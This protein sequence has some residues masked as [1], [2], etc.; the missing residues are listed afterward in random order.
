[1]PLLEQDFARRYRAAQEREH[2]P[3]DLVKST[4]SLVEQAEREHQHASA[5]DARY[6]RDRSDA[7]PSEPPT[8]RRDDSGGL[9]GG[10]GTV[11]P[12][13]SPRNDRTSHT[14]RHDAR[15]PHERSVTHRHPRWI[16][17]IAACLAAS[18][19][20]FGIGSAILD[21]SLPFIKD[22][23][24]TRA[25]ARTPNLLAADADGAIIPFALDDF[26]NFQNPLSFVEGFTG[27]M[28]T[29]EGDGI[30]RVQATIDRG[31][32]YSMTAET[33]TR[34]KAE[35]VEK[36]N[37]AL[38][39]SHKKRG[40]GT[41]LR[42]Y[43]LVTTIP[44]DDGFDYS[45]ANKSFE[46]RMAK[47]LGSTI[48]VAYE[49]GPLTLGLWFDDV[50]YIEEPGSNGLDWRPYLHG[51]DGR[52]LT[53][54]TVMLDGSCS[55]Q[56]IE[57]HDGWFSILPAGETDQGADWITAEGPFDA[58]PNGV[59][60]ARQT[61][62]GEVTS[63]TDQPHPFPLDGASE[64]AD[65]PAD[66]YP[67]EELIDKASN[68][69]V[70]GVPREDQIV[71][72]DSS[73]SP[74]GA[75]LMSEQRSNMRCLQWS[76]VSAYITDALPDD[77][78]IAQLLGSTNDHEYFNR[79]NMARYGWSIDEEG[80][81][82]GNGSFLVV[83]ATLTNASDSPITFDGFSPVGTPCIVDRESNTTV[84]P[85]SGSAF[86][87]SDDRGR[88]WEKNVPALEPRETVRLRIIYITDDEMQAAGELF[89]SPDDLYLDPSVGSQVSGRTFDFD[90]YLFIS[91]GKLE[92]R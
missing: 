57:L 9:A 38:N 76:D 43:D 48:D 42:D 14:A 74:S 46:T 53:L 62:Y 69:V 16:A 73:I 36:L 82:S 54:T 1:M 78:D 24:P 30:A 90:P 26:M 84:L 4:R 18:L 32:L 27:M 45:D 40:M 47:R 56:T 17:P 61:L 72:T 64:R 15:K 5:A 63:I 75:R 65:S 81:I 28:F 2:A 19:A 41:Y 3:A 50:T 87:T 51:L 29:V 58:E 89:Y 59:E 67:L 8:N 80:S 23:A 7:R 35:D 22:Q 66:P 33:L 85:S 52:T 21:P 20:L 88:N 13:S 6:R 91:L 60:Q 77:V 39:W 25:Y 12:A 49:Q 79:A 44:A 71:S 11:F 55:T 83:N 37:E 86:T 10:D 31:E 34:S 70:D 92:R 68:V